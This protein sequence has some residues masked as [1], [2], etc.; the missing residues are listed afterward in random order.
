MARAEDTTAAPHESGT[1]P[2]PMPSTPRAAKPNLEAAWRTA[3]DQGSVSRLGILGKGRLMCA[4]VVCLL[5]PQASL[6]QETAYRW[7]DAEGNIHFG[8]T[9]P[10]G[11]ALQVEPL[12]LAPNQ[13]PVTNDDYYSIQNQLERTEAW[14]EERE[15]RRRTDEPK[16]DSGRGEGGTKSYPKQGYPTPDPYF[17][18]SEGGFSPY[19]GPYPGDH[20]AYWPDYPWHRPG[21]G[22]PPPHR[23]HRSEPPRGRLHLPQ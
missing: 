10:V 1:Q 14:R 3:R 21:W 23:G 9:P 13:A 11:G 18:P 2:I 8:D 22:H 12:E 20:P 5:G 6:A 4:L 16:G 17:W 15:Q 19:Y 7:T